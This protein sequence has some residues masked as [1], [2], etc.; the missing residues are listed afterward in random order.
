[1][2]R[3]K[4]QEKRREQENRK[5]LIA[6]NDGKGTEI[7]KRNKKEII[8][9]LIS[10]VFVV[11]VVAAA[12]DGGDGSSGSRGGGGGGVGEV[13]IGGGGGGCPA[14]AAD[15]DVIFSRNGNTH[16]ALIIIIIIITIT[17]L[18]SRSR[19][20]GQSVFIDLVGTAP[21][22]TGNEARLFHI[23]S[24]HCIQSFKDTFSTLYSSKSAPRIVMNR[25]VR[26][27]LQ[28]GTKESALPIRSA[29]LILTRTFAKVSTQF[30]QRLLY[31]HVEV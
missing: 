28:V 19:N 13:G 1:L 4:D 29:A 5:G 22:R 20:T 16:H 24:S 3:V 31:R 9:T 12:G 27:S 10:T 15:D 11:I 26:L 23:N 7:L 25:Y 30:L 8:F 18:Q 2:E 21:C 17:V 14:A 6:Q